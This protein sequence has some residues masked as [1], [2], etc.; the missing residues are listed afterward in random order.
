MYNRHYFH[1]PRATAVITINDT[2]NCWVVF[3]CRSRRLDYGLLVFPYNLLIFSLFELFSSLKHT[4][5]KSCFCYSVQRIKT[6]LFSKKTK[7]RKDF[8]MELNQDTITDISNTFT[9]NVW[10]FSVFDKLF[11]LFILF[12]NTAWFLVRRFLS[13]KSNFLLIALVDFILAFMISKLTVQND[14]TKQTVD[15]TLATSARAIKNARYSL[16]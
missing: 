4:G 8:G 16:H 5:K 11:N 9:R 7:A 2:V 6:T 3:H 10:H 14:I 12:L 15:I 1:T 13:F